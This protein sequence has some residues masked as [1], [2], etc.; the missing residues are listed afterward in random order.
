MFDEGGELKDK[1]PHWRYAWKWPQAKPPTEGMVKP[2]VRI[3]RSVIYKLVIKVIHESSPQKNS[4]YDEILRSVLFASGWYLDKYPDVA[5]AGVDP[6]QHYLRHGAAEGRDPGP[7]FSTRGYLARYTDVAESGINPLVHYIRHGK[8]EGR[9]ATPFTGSAGA[10]RPYRNF[11][12]YLKYALLNPMVEAPFVE[13]DKRAF[14]AMENVAH[15]L[16]NKA[17]QAKDKPL[18]SVIMPVHNREGI[19]SEA[20]RSVLA[21]TYECFEL[22]VVDDCSS[23]RSLEVVHSFGEEKI[24]S[25][26]V[27]EKI[28]VSAARNHGIRAARGELIAYLDSDNTWLPDYLETMVG[29]FHELPNAD[30]AYC[31]QYLYRGD[32]KAPFAVRYGSFNP[33]LLLNRNYID[34]N[35]FMHRRAVLETIGGGFCEEMRRLVD[36]ELILRIAAAGKIYSVP[37]IKSNYFFDKT[38]N[39]ITDVVDIGLANKAL[40]AR[41]AYGYRNLALSGRPLQKKVAVIIPSYEVLEALKSCL[42]SMVDL[43]AD[44][45][46]QII[47]VDNASGSA[48]TNYLCELEGAGVKVLFN[49]QNYGFSHAVNQGVALADPD[50]D[51]FLLNNDAFLTPGALTVLQE[52]AHACDSIAMT[53]PQQVL[54]A[55]EPTISTHVPYAIDKLPCDVTLSCHH[56]NV[57]HLPLFHDGAVVELNFSPFFC[58]YIKRDA[59]NACGGLDAEHG[60]HYRS[61]RIMCDYV[62]HVLAKRI[63]YTPEAIVFHHHQAATKELRGKSDGNPDFEAMFQRNQWPEEM[64]ERLGY[65]RP[66]WDQR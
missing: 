50:S 13:E 10:A 42:A 63:V 59:W 31:G 65:R 61:D 51:I 23:D 29:A 48:V 49:D 56:G 11:P 43:F 45:L 32:D 21:Q 57:E 22:I 40:M 34:L 16:R 37:V 6:L 46:V 41:S 17:A 52:A 9:V 25:I 62:R 36:W 20:I 53:T 14:A 5:A 64:G 33:T 54:S 39:A 27:D 28:G 2:A 26:A 8:D 15:W 18:V 38:D 55:G 7:K 58:V 30:A 3:F 44:P 12:E 60:R 1:I 4:A 66:R 35:C 24:R 19:V 47:V